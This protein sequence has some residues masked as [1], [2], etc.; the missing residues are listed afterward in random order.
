MADITID[1]SV[2]SLTYLGGIRLGPIWVSNLI[3]YIFYTN[4]D[5]DL[6]Y[7]KTIDGGA[8][9]ESEV[10]VHTGTTYNLSVWYDRWTTGITGRK[11][12]I[13]Y[14]DQVTDDIFHRSLDTIGDD[15]ST[16]VVVFAG[17]SIGGGRWDLSVLDIIKARGGNLYIGF[18]G[19][20]DGEYG[21]YRSTN[22]GDDWTSRAQLADGNA[23]DGILF[24]P[25]GETDEDDIWCIYW[26][27][28]AD[29]L[30]LKVYDNSADSWAETLI[31]ASMVDDTNY[32]QVSASQRHSDNRVTLVA[33]SELNAATADLKV[34]EI[35]SA[36]AIDAFGSVVSNLDNAGQVAVFI[37]QQNDDTYVAYL[38]GGTWGDTVDVMY[39]K[40]TD[41]GFTW[42]DEQVYS[43][44]AADDL[45]GVWAGVSVGNDGGRFQPAF[46]NR[47]LQDLFTNFVNGVSIEGI[48]DN[49]PGTAYIGAKTVGVPSGGSAKV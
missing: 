39:K 8:T 32:I 23:V 26:D 2:S 41:G 40:S 37:N 1:D 48:V 28:S 10:T 27:R 11:V 20:A 21:F 30:S 15:L 47:D 42:G 6:V 13:A 49:P 7:R 33:W 3:G 17:T 22:E 19:D 31:S 12:H 25:G 36:A 44:G 34:W 38:K 46:F 18:W 14:M 4:S 45:V 24:M 29:E 35:A 43:E 9:W 5:T 16:A